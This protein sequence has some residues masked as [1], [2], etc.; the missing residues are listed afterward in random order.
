MLTFVS[1]HCITKNKA[2]IAHNVTMLHL[3]VEASKSMLMY[4]IKQKTFNT[5]NVPDL[6]LP[7]E[8]FTLMATQYSVRQG[9]FNAYDA[10]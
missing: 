5:H 7:R 3:T 8:I 10:T 1:K 4:K 2:F 9:T 6:H